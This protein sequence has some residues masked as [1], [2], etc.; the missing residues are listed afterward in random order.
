MTTHT[1]ETCGV[2]WSQHLHCW[3]SGQLFASALTLAQGHSRAWVTFG[4]CVATKH[5]TSTTVH[6]CAFPGLGL[7]SRSVL[8]CAPLALPIPCGRLLVNSER[9]KS[10][11]HT[12]YCPTCIKRWD[13][14]KNAC[15]RYSNKHSLRFPTHVWDWP[16]CAL[17]FLCSFVLNFAPVCFEQLYCF[18]FLVLECFWQVRAV[19][20]WCCPLFL[21]QLVFLFLSVV[22]LNLG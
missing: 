14:G 6:L 17:C 22:L 4:V 16:Q 12:L 18:H 10:A 20:L 5:R 8:G 2:V 7:V 19:S 9:E 21:V 11:W 3:A 15:G 13:E 1:L